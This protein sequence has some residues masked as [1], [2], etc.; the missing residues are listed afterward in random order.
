M[1]ANQDAYNLINKTKQE[2]SNMIPKSSGAEQY[3]NAP[4]VMA[5][6]KCLDD[7]DTISSERTKVNDEAIQK[8]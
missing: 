3:A 4:P 6:K 7:L 2:L 5:L 8:L 1:K